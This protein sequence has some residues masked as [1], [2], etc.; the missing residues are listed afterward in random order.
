MRTLCVWLPWTPLNQ[1]H[2][3]HTSLFPLPLDAAGGQH[4]NDDEAQYG[5]DNDD[6]DQLHVI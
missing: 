1:W 5:E 4:N 2:C 3:T 6:E